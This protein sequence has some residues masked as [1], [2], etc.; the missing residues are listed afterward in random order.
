[1]TAILVQV[2]Q[3]LAWTKFC[4][5]TTA[6][7]FFSKDCCCVGRQIRQKQVGNCVSTIKMISSHWSATS[8]LVNYLCG[9]SCLYQL[10]HKEHL[11][12]LEGGYRKVWLAQTN[13]ILVNF[14]FY[15]LFWFWIHTHSNPIGNKCVKENRKKYWNQGER[16]G[17]N[18]QK[19]KVV[20]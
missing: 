12:N 3:F 1:M 8:S 15:Q 16:N 9:K 19:Q 11:D 5:D 18:G 20:F 17:N 6:K 2:D 7:K 4:D 13:G 14:C 10:E